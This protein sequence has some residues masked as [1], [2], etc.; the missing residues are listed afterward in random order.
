V[1]HI[2]DAANELVGRYNIME[3]N[4]YQGL[5]HGCLNHIFELAKILCQVRPEPVVP[6]RKSTAAGTAPAPRKTSRKCGHGR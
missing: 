6:N 1:A 5:R 2:E 4:A 3:N